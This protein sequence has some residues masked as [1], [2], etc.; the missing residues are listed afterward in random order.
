MIIPRSPSP[1]AAE[2]GPGP[3]PEFKS[4]AS[5]CCHDSHAQERDAEVFPAELVEDEEGKKK[6]GGARRREK[7]KGR[8]KHSKS[9]Y[10]IPFYIIYRHS[11]C[12]MAHWTQD[13][14]S[15]LQNVVL[16]AIKF[17]FPHQHKIIFYFFKIF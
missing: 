8:G 5:S 15:V 3:P 4:H 12:I 13:M 17:E 10:L 14:F 2:S 16:T 6:E 11:C 1:E 7:K 9:L